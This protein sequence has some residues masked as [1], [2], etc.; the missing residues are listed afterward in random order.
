MAESSFLLFLSISEKTLSFS[1]VFFVA[2]EREFGTGCGA[3]GCWL[4]PGSTLNAM[5]ELEPAERG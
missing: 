5:L 3:A 4:G 1:P 2:F